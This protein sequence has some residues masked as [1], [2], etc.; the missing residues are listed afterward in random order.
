M[1]LEKFRNKGR[2][3][4]LLAFAIFI[5]SVFGVIMIFSASGVLAEN[6]YG[7]LYFFARKQT[8]ALVVGLVLMVILSKINYKIWRQYATTLL[9]VTIIL[10]VAVFLPMIGVDNKGAH[11][12]IDLGFIT[13]QPSELV[14]ITFLLYLSAWLCKKGKEINVFASGFVPFIAI[15]GIVTVLV[16]AEPDMGSMT[17]IAAIATVIFLI[18]G[19]SWKYV[20]IYLGGI[21]LAFRMLI[22][23]EPYRMERLKVFLNPASALQ[24]AGYQIN[25]AMLAIGSGGWAGLGF[26]QSRQKYLYLPEPHTDSIFAIIAEE[27]GFIRVILLVL[28]F[29]FIAWRGYG[30]AL[31]APDMFGRLVASGITTWIVWQAFVNMG[32]M[33]GLLPLTGVTLPFISYGGTS[34]VVTLAAVGILLNISRKNA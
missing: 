25:Q 31:K 2:I 7:N 17:V 23:I 33:T 10:L 15:L 27:L 9:W 1:G 8:I 29:V 21:F 18:S 4:Y 19:V 16:M 3:D 24:G 12:W 13:F 22:I 26:G 30:I 32:A 6:V 14:K 34:L 28:V 20:F 11:R 5:L